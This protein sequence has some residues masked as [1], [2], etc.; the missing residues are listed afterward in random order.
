MR[1]V[2]ASA[3]NVLSLDT[4]L[5]SAPSCALETLDRWFVLHVKSRQEKVLADELQ[6]LGISHFLPKLTQT[7]FHGNRKA[8]VTSPMFPGY[9]F[10]RGSLDEA[11]R[12]GN[13]K[14]IARVLPVVNQ[15]ELNWELRN[16][17]LALLQSAPLELYPFLRSGVRVEVRSGP[18]R[19][20]QGIITD[21]SG[22]TRLMLQVAMLGQAASLEIDG[23]LLDVLD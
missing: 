22:A 1:L 4:S 12:A 8:Q 21:R 3:E 2:C 11:Y 17:H 6:T 20:V 7:R 23:S 18:F 14:R 13:T 15:D 9:M 10:L 5:F 19:G 16:L